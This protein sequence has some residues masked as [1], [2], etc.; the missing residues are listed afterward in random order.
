LAGF[1]KQLK[2]LQ[3][4]DVSIVAGSVDDE[5]KAGEIAADLSYPI[6]H[7]VTKEQADML[8]SFW[9]DRRSIIQPSE[10]ILDGDG[11]ILD[12]MYAAGPIGRLGAEETVSYI[13]FLESKKD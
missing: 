3:A 10:F 5:E 9:E 2:E 12:L 6:A 13:E 4:L 7:G 8:G 11:N 1:E